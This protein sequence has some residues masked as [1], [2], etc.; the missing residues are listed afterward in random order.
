MS[1][2]AIEHQVAA[3]ETV[4]SCW[5]CR[6]TQRGELKGTA[7]TG[8]TMEVEGISILHLEN[9]RIRDQTTVWDALGLMRP[10]PQPNA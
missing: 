7:A 6:G 10:S 1:H 8:K 4:V 3:S 5:R 2:F 9:G